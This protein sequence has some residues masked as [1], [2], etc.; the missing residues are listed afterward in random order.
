M[1]L[2]IAI[3]VLMFATVGHATQSAFT[4]NQLL[5]LCESSLATERSVCTGYLLGHTDAHATL[6]NWEILKEQGFCLP[7]NVESGQMKLVVIKGLREK[8]EKLHLTGASLVYNIF[9]DAFP[10]D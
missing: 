6:T 10:C 1:K 4:G 9:V 3:V 8:P 7:S 5:G 2:W